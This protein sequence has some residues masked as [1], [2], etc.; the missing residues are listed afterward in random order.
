MATTTNF[1]WT[2]PAVGADSDVWGGYLNTDLDSIDTL[3]GSGASGGALKVNT[4]TLGGATLGSNALAVSGTAA[5]SGSLT[6]S[7]TSGIIGTTTNNSADAGSVGEVVSSTVLVASPVVLTASTTQTITSI[8]LTAGDW[9]ISAAY[10]LTGAATT[11]VSRISVCINTV[12]N[13]MTNLPATQNQIIYVPAAAVFNIQ[14][15]YSTIGT[16]RVSIATTTTY[17]LLSNINFG[18]STCSGFGT[19]RAR[20]MR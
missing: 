8:S 12:N 17:Y 4:L 16:S 3:L 5:I 2:K 19:L 14:D 11:T 18:I 15:I 6:T 1:G 9:D 10:G 13:A 7:Q 20:R